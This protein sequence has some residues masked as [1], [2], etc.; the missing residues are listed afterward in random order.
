[1]GMREH[2][3]DPFHAEPLGIVMRAVVVLAALVLLVAAA[4]STRPP[5][6]SVYVADCQSQPGASCIPQ[7]SAIR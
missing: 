2:A 5:A 6:S 1:M 3:V 4:R 7:A